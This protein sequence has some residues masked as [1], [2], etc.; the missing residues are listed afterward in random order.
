V[1]EYFSK[2]SRNIACSVGFTAVATSN[3]Q[4]LDYTSPAQR[5]CSTSALN[6]ALLP[7]ASRRP[8]GSD[9]GITHVG[10]DAEFSSACALLSD[11]RRIDVARR[12]AR[13]EKRIFA[14]GAVRVVRDLFRG[15]FLDGIVKALEQGQLKLPV[16]TS[17]QRLKNLLNQLGRKKWNVC[18]RERYSHGTGV[19]TYLARYVRGGPLSNQK[20]ECVDEAGVRFR[21]RDH[22]DGKVKPMTLRIEEFIER[23][24]RH[25]PEKGM[26]V[27][28]HYGLYGRC[29][30]ALRDRCRAELH[31]EGESAA[32]VLTVGQ[33]L[34]KTGYGEKLSCRVC[35]ERMICVDRFG[36]AGPELLEYRRKAA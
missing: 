26:V 12:M 25:V 23:A 31:Q 17:E 15:K 22:R 8:G 5:V 6:G 18:I 4:R 34:E 11:R 33:Y 32:K 13:G 29:G 10:A 27:L 14:T 36:R 28:R 1:R 24:L 9:D 2:F 20:L 35:G 30:K 7:G 16:Q 21:Y 19:I 3:D